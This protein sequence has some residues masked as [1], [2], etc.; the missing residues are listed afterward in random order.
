MFWL[1]V[2]QTKKLRYVSPSYE[3]VFGRSCESLLESR[4][5]WLDLVHPDE[6]DHVAEVFAR[7]AELGIVTDEE[8]RIVTDDGEERWLRDQAFP[9]LDEG[10]IVVRIVGVAEDITKRKR[11]EQELEQFAEAMQS[12]NQAL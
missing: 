3:T 8:Y 11:T 1:T 2:G 12:S 7:N 9:I 6:R 4:R 10:G 5:S